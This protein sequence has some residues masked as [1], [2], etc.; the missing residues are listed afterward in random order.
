VEPCLVGEIPLNGEI[1]IPL[2]ENRSGSKHPSVKHS[3]QRLDLEHINEKQSHH[4]TE[5][6]IFPTKSAGRSWNATKN[7]RSRSR[8]SAFRKSPA[9]PLPGD[10]LA[11]IDRAQRVSYNCG[12]STVLS[13]PRP[14]PSFF[15]DET[16]QAGST[17]GCSNGRSK[18][19]QP[20]PAALCPRN[21]PAS[22]AAEIS[23]IRIL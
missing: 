8:I 17:L 14:S 10:S 2:P 22:N 19:R 12:Q 3:G 20:F 21:N 11:L 23:S 5:T 7:R 15:D 18:V 1:C 9:L 4:Q 16:E 13:R 6:A